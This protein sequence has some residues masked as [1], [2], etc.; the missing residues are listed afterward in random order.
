MDKKEKTLVI[1]ASTKPERYSNMA[2]KKLRNH[3]HETIALG[4]RPGKIS[5]VDITTEQ[6]V[7]DDIHTVTVYVGADRLGP[8]EDY[9]LSLKPERI[10][11]NPGAENPEFAKRAK[12]AGIEIVHAC[13]LVM[14]STDQY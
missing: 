11:F 2:V 13:T 4:L 6:I 1:G 5:D 8:S 3:G 12:E 10:I 7:Y 9:L 14:L